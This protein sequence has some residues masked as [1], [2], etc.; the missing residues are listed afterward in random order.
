MRFFEFVGVSALVLSAVAACGGVAGSTDEPPAGSGDGGP[1]LDTGSSPGQDSAPEDSGTAG[2]SGA[3][4]AADA[5]SRTFPCGS[6]SCAMA[7]QYCQVPSG[8]P[9]GQVARCE[10]IPPSCGASPT[11]A[12]VKPSPGASCVDDGGQLT[13]DPCPECS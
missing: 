9:A 8:G 13:V 3:G 10:P 5:G 6:T 2:D 12:C 1:A 11:C 7:T 4:D